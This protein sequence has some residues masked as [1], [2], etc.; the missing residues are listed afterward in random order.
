[1]GCTQTYN[2]HAKLGKC[3]KRQG[4]SG[5]AFFQDTGE[6]PGHYTAAQ[7]RH[8]QSMLLAVTSLED[9]QL[10][11]ALWDVEGINQQVWVIESCMQ[12]I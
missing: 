9:D 7:Y 10:W 1:M 12:T 5:Y 4:V 6:L 2:T 3:N 11:G 8:T